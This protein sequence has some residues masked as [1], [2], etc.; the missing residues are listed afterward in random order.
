MANLRGWGYHAEVNEWPNRKPYYLHKDLLTADGE[1]GKRRGDVLVTAFATIPDQ[2]NYANK[3]AW[4]TRPDDACTCTW[5]RLWRERQKLELEII[6]DVPEVEAREHR[7][8]G[9]GECACGWKSSAPKSSSRN[10]AVYRHIAAVK[11][12]VAA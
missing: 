2:V 5:C 6:Q 8:V 10:S 1:I 4:L 11:E 12:P 3:G 9:A 7:K